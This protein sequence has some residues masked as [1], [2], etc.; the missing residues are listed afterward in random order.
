MIIGVIGK[1]TRFEELK[2]TFPADA[3]IRHK[4]F[5]T[6]EE[7]AACDIYFDLDFEIHTDKLSVYS[8]IEN[9]IFFLSA[10]SLE[11]AATA[12]QHQCTLNHR[13]FGLNCLPGFINRPLKEISIRDKSQET[14]AA[15]VLD[16]LGWK[17]GFVKD[18]V[19]MASPRILF[20]IIN[21]AY[22]TLQEGTA[23]KE[24]IDTAM[25]LGTNYPSG[26]FEWCDK[27]GVEEVVDLLDRMYDDT[28]DERYKV[29]SL[30]RSQRYSVES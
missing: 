3:E 5:S 12:Y 23:S 30:L 28:H 25:K 6:P 21:E 20:M 13:I 22:Y 18:R 4:G 1:L 7:I 15:P 8:V 19:G 27:I 17:A 16:Q 10:A 11:L 24:D 14:I 9:T 26:P 2:Q 29:C